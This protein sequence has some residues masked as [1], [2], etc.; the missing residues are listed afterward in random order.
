MPIC[1]RMAGAMP[2]QLPPTARIFEAFILFRQSPAD[3]QA[4]SSAATAGFP[5]AGVPARRADA[6]RA[7]K[8]A[9]APLFFTWAKARQA[10]MRSSGRDD[11][12]NPRLAVLLRRNSAV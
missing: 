1:S 8:S 3:R 10:A 2:G 12:T 5:G 7:P 6:T 11:A 4:S 9:A